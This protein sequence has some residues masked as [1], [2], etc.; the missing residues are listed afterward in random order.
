MKTSSEN[1]C[2]T[3][4][5][6]F[7]SQNCPHQLKW[8]KNQPHPS[9]SKMSRPKKRA[10][11][12][13]FSRNAVICQ[14]DGT[15]CLLF[16]VILWWIRTRREKDAIWNSGWQH[17]TQHPGGSSCSGNSYKV[18]TPKHHIFKLYHHII[19][20]PPLLLLSSSPLLSSLSS[21]SLSLY[22]EQQASDGR[23]GGDAVLPDWARCEPFIIIII[24]IMTLV[25]MV[26][27]MK[28][29]DVRASQKE[30]L[31]HWLMFSQNTSSP[32]SWSYLMR[33]ELT[34]DPAFYSTSKS[35]M[36]GCFFNFL[37]HLNDDD[38]PWWCFW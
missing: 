9:L 35:D 30:S 4:L 16:R 12:L 3:F 33:F 36:F 14:R 26:L 37:A 8:T 18:S 2:P 20:S 31:T 38:F 24:I 5:I 6:S 7:W 32:L 17:A 29:S 21:L 15:N 1:M 11:T 28:F 13:M 19:I 10:S 23:G 25:S 27:V 22:G 34:A